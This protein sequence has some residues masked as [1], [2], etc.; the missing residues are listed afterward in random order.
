MRATEYSRQG[1]LAVGA[2]LAPIL[3][4]SLPM[5]DWTQQ[6]ACEP[7]FRHS[8]RT[9]WNHERSESLISEPWK[10]SSVGRQA[11]PTLSLTGGPTGVSLVITSMSKGLTS[12]DVT[13]AKVYEYGTPAECQVRSHGGN[14][15]I[16]NDRA[17]VSSSTHLACPPWLPRCLL[18]TLAASEPAALTASVFCNRGQASSVRAG[19]SPGSSAPT[20]PPACLEARVSLPTPFEQ[21]QARGPLWVL[22]SDWLHGAKVMPM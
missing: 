1:S 10:R 7:T 11:C 19:L 8:S 3:E 6:H 17:H 14:T 21:S 9:N 4:I 5:T 12:Q 2:R 16:H 20:T 22:S 13:L 15:P 18:G